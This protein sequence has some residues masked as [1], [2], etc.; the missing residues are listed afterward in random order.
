MHCNL[1][2][3]FVQFGLFVCLR[4]SYAF[5]F[6]CLSCSFLP[7]LPQTKIC[8]Y[9]PTTT[10]TRIPNLIAQSSTYTCFLRAFV[11]KNIAIELSN[12]ILITLVTEVY[13]FVWNFFFIPP[14]DNGF[15]LRKRW[16]H[17][18]LVTWGIREKK[19]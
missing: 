6:I 14:N 4:S 17:E 9:G 10:V 8:V 1:Y 2:W 13:S 3:F 11:K 5:H 12:N 19:R 15:D 7:C 18:R 16:R